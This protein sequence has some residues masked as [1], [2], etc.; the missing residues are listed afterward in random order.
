MPSERLFFVRKNSLVGVSEVNLDQN[1]AINLLKKMLEIYSPS[2]L[3]EEISLFL[4]DEMR[5]MGFDRVWRNNIGNVYGEIG[6][7]GP[8]VLLCGHMDTV[9]GRIPVRVEGGRIYGRGAV[10]A[11]SSLAAMINAALLLK[12]SSPRGRVIVAGVVDEEEGGKGIRSLLKENINVDCAIF[13]EPSGI[14]SVTFAYKGHLKL[15]VA[16][17]TATGHLGA[18]HLLS[19]A[20]EEEIRFWFKLKKT[21]EE[22]YKSPHGIFYSLTPSLTKVYGRGTTDSVPDICSMSIDLRL[23]PTI[24]PK[25][26]IEIISRVIEEFKKESGCNISFKVT[27]M[28]EPYIADR[29]NIVIRSLR[30]T[31]LEET[32]REANLVRKTG[33]GDMNIFGLRLKVPVAAYGPGE[34]KLSHTYCEYISIQEY[35]ASIKIYKRA[36]EKIFS[37]LIAGRS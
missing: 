16:C 12:E 6:F 7:A 4:A 25:K 30:E 2:G 14:N 34:S 13:G 27:G 19:N 20:I 5:R 9:P 24:P 31:I 8:T 37:C 10:D 32:G 21:C 3:E 1:Y 29:E 28:V 35:I 33:T 11:K 26:A 36:L 17:K 18:Q 22:K 23:P 15:R